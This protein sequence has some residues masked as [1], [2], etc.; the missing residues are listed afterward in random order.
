MKLVN[1]KIEGISFRAAHYTGGVIVPTIVVL[2]D[3]A[4]RLEKGSSAAYLASQ[5]ASR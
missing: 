3:T 2:H 1:H 4:G 5:K